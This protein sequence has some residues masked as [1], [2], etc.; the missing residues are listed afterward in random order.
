LDEAVMSID[1]RA[2]I[3][4]KEIKRRAQLIDVGEER[5]FSALPMLHETG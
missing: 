1:E 5:L 2:L 3:V 4:L